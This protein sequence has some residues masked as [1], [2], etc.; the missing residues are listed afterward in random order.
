VGGTCEVDLFGLFVSLLCFISE[1]M[2]SDVIFE[3]RS[4]RD[5]EGI[6]FGLEKGW[7]SEKWWR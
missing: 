3:K 7:R 2:R 5:V 4:L 1:E 6:L